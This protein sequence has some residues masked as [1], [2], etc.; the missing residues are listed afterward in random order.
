MPHLTRYKVKLDDDTIVFKGKE[1]KNG[2]EI[3]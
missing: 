3:I 2:G 1:K